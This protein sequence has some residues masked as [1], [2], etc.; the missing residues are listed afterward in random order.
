MRQ[1]PIRSS[2]QE[3]A[4]LGGLSLF[5]GLDMDELAALRSRMRVMRCTSGEE[6]FAE[7]DAGDELFVLVEGRV[8]IGLRLAD[9]DEIVV[10]EVLPG[11]FFGEMSIF[12]RSPRSASCRCTESSVLLAL[13]SAGFD[14][15]AGER[16]RAASRIMRKML[17]IQTE[18]LFATGSLVSQMV[19]W[20]EAARRRAVTDEATGLFNRRFLDD[21]LEGLFSRARLEA[22]PLSLGMFDLDHFGD[23]NRA[24]GQEFGDA[25]IVEVSKAFRKAFRDGDILVRY[26][27]DEFTFVMPGAES[28][29]AAALCG[30]ACRKVRELRLEAAP[31]LRVTAS[32]GYATYPGEAS[33]L[34]ALV[35][36]ADAALYRA[37]ERGRDRAEGPD[38]VM[39]ARRIE[40]S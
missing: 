3:A 26:G 12:D 30:E 5:S 14:A 31:E 22:G 17:G 16:P 25:V 34:E 1:T 28:G 39:P 18:R 29:T 27:G 19:Q 36:A 33:S 20:G 2:E 37:K 4:G 7:G 9:G 10:S 11:G 35:A 24:R 38:G 23:L 8:S 6:V 15:F 40:G 32:I 13:G 21:S